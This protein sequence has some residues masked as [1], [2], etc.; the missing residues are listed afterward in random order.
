[1]NIGPRAWALLVGGIV[2]LSLAACSQAAPPAP[3]A[4]AAGPQATSAVEGATPQGTVAGHFNPTEAVGGGANSSSAVTDVSSIFSAVPQAAQLRISANSTPP[5]ASGAD[6][7]S[8]SVLAQDGG[9]LL[10][11]LDAAGKQALGNAILDAARTAWP[12][13]TVSLLVSDPT[14][15]G[16]IIGTQPKGGTNT[17][18]AT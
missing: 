13:A 10:K 5:G 2:A 16:Q 1:M 3:T 12:N 7:Q 4:T 6:V 14:G 8:V 11:S 15:G 9:G 18:I 17:V